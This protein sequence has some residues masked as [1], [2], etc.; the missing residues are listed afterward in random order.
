[1]KDLLIETLMPFGYPVYQQGS[2]SRDEQYP[3]SFFTFWNND[4]DDDSFYDNEPRQTIWEF[5]LMFYSID[6]VLVN[7]MLIRAKEKLKE[8]GFIVSG[9]GYDV[10]SD[11]PSHTGRGINVLKNRI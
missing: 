5:D 10:K 3:E 9:D 6:P 1:M 8:K 7:E 2:L 11:E 4:T